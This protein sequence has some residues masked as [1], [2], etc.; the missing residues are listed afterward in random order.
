MRSP[1]RARPRLMRAMAGTHGQAVLSAAAAG[2]CAYDDGARVT[3]SSREQSSTGCNAEAATDENGLITVGTLAEFVEQHV[4]SWIRK[5][6]DVQVVRATQVTWDGQT[7]TMPLAACRRVAAER[8]TDCM[9]A[10]GSMPGGATVSLDGQEVGKTPVSIRLAKEQS[11]EVILVKS[12]YRVATTDVD[13]R[14]SEPVFIELRPRADRLEVLLNDTF[15]DNRNGWYLSTEAGSEGRIKNGTYSLGT[16]DGELRF[17]AVAPVFN[18]D[19]DFE[20]SV[21]ARYVS[22]P[23]DSIFGLVWGATRP[24]K[25]WLFAINS[26]GNISVGAIDVNSGGVP[27]NDIAVV[28][29]AVRTGG[30][31]NRLKIVRIGTHLR[32]LVNES[33]V[34]E[35]NRAPSFGAGVGLVVLDGPVVAAFDDFRVEG[36]RR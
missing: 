10:I 13:C 11:G 7:G 27:V 14:R 8:K 29:Q 22:G 1:M 15:D 18:E 30:S 16:K 6:R 34:Y 20:L 32:F 3:E 23:E 2:R 35:M 19:A 25:F 28:H 31:L 21:T 36:H 33:V 12:G 17:T 9:I 24:G 26:K 4:L 5:N